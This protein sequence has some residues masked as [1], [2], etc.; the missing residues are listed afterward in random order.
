MNIGIIGLGAFAE[1]HLQAIE[2]IPDLQVTSVSRRNKEALA[3]FCEKHNSVKGYSDY[4]DLLCSEEIDAVL[5]ATPH[6]MHTEIVEDAAACGKHILLEKPLAESPEG[7]ARIRK[8]VVEHNIC[9]MTG[10]SNHFTKANRKAKELIDSGEIGSILSGMSFVHKYWMVPERRDWHLH[11]STGGGMWLT[12][13]VH[14]LDR[15]SFF[16]N[17]RIRSISAEMGTF[18]HKQDADDSATAYLRFENGATGVV[19]AIGYSKGGPVEETMLVGTK[20]SL[21][22]NQKKG[23]LIGQNDTWVPMENTG[24]EDQHV[25]SLS[26]EWRVFKRYIETG[27]A[28]HMITLDFAVHIMDAIFA[29]QKSSEEHREIDIDIKATGSYI[30]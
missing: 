26:E 15:L 25:D 20:G 17:S 2:L 9:F 11:R 13:G 19:T 10:F 16:M 18:F 6:H 30:S 28:Q 21:K 7:V 24:T 5:I 29:A 23:I 22:I 4:H 3:S 12:I 8:A 1:Y 14:L 27:Q